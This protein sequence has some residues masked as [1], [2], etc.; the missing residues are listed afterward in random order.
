MLSKAK[1]KQTVC[2]FTLEPLEHCPNLRTAKKKKICP[3]SLEPCVSQG[4]S[5]KAC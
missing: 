2:P 1:D 3:F 4:K 5:S